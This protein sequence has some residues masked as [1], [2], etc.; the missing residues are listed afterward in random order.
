[1]QTKEARH[2]ANILSG[3]GLRRRV[4]ITTSPSDSESR[5]LFDML[6]VDREGPYGAFKRHVETPHG[7]NAASRRV[8]AGREEIKCL[9]NHASPA[10]CG[11]KE[12]GFPS[13]SPP[14]LSSNL[15]LFRCI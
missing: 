8:R 6:M 13:P 2:N 15:N 14:S 12:A 7:D 3:F 10:S 5:A 11:G 9:C 4:G 1:V